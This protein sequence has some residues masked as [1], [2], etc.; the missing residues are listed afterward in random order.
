MLSRGGGVQPRWRRDGKEL[1]YRDPSTNSLMSVDVTLNPTF[2][3]R[4]PKELFRFVGFFGGV[5]NLFD[6]SGDGQLVIRNTLAG[7]N[8]PKTPQT[9]MTVVLNWTAGLRK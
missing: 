2:N 8:D 1:F 4:P 9:P 5:A 3:A 6:V 7:E